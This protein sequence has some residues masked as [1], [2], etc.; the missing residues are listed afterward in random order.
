MPSSKMGFCPHLDEGNAMLTPEVK[1][2]YGFP[3]E[4]LLQM[5]AEDT[6]QSNQTSQR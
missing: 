6:F 2:E 3:A 4:A 5:G 1:Q